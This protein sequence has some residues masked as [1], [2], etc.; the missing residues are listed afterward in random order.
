MARVRDSPLKIDLIK[1]LVEGDR[2]HHRQIIDIAALSIDKEGCRFSQRPPC[3]ATVLSR[4]VCGFGTCKRVACVKPRG[5]PHHEE[6]SMKFI[7]SW[8]GEDL[9]A[10]VTELVVLR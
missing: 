5:V 3:V 9:D 1:I 4:M 8:L 7:G 2:V 10:S 6:L